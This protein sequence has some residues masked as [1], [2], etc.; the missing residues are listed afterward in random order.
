MRERT[1]GQAGV[2]HPGPGEQHESWVRSTRRGASGPRP[3]RPAVPPGSAR[4]E[5]GPRPAPAGLGGTSAR[6]SSAATERGAAEAAARRRVESAAERGTGRAALERGA[7][8]TAA[9]RWAERIAAERGAG[10]PA[11]RGGVRPVVTGSDDGGVAVERGTT[12]RLGVC[13]RA[14]NGVAHIGRQTAVKEPRL[15]VRRPLPTTAVPLGRVRRVVVGL[16]VV[17]AAA[18]VVFGLG[19]VADAAAH[20]RV[21]A[22]P[23]AA[24]VTIT[25]DAPGTVWDVADGVAP[26]ASGPERAAM[27]DRIVAAN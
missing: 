21:S 23:V 26:G 5:A 14:G 2:D 24:E 1:Q 6:A 20:A 12:G 18:A 19:R 8:R 16:A 4:P 25:V 7:G 22:A 13:G 9:E 15:L 11:V 10:Q 17:L 3:V 27:V